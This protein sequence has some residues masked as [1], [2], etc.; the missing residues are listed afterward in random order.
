MEKLKIKDLR[1]KKN[2]LQV[3]MAI[4]LNQSLPSY[5]NRE[6]GKI[7]FNIGEAKTICEFF[8]VEI[9]EIDWSTKE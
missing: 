2:L 1:K 7:P 4:L 5:I 6:N 3:D 8:N 9:N